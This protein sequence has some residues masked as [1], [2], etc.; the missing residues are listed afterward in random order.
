MSNNPLLLF[1]PLFLLILGIVE[2]VFANKFAAFY[3]KNAKYEWRPT[4]RPM[5]ESHYSIGLVRGIG[6]GMVVFSILIVLLIIAGG[7]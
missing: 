3:K 4:A 7:N 6:V 2:I 1:L 5:S